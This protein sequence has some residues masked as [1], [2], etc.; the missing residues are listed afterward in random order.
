MGGGA[1]LSRLTMTKDTALT[2]RERLRIHFREA[3]RTTD[4]PIVEAQLNAALDA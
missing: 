1:P 3:R 2:A 4:S